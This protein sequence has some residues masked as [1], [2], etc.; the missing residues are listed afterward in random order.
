MRRRVVLNHEPL[1]LQLCLESGNLPLV[2]RVLN[3]DNVSLLDLREK[4]GDT[5]LRE[6]LFL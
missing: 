5:F 2:A 1:L 3:N 4:A 6:Q